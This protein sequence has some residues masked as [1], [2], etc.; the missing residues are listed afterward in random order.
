[1]LKR[2][3][4]K[5]FVLAETG[6]ESAWNTTTDNDPSA[7]PAPQ[8]VISAPSIEVVLTN[9]ATE[10]ADENVVA[11]ENPSTSQRLSVPVTIKSGM[12]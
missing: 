7:A 4:S 11:I 12:K 9:N 5:R 10:I 3:P 1:M 2:R 6:E 8:A